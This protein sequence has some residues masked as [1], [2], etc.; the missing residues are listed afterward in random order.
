M[1]RSDLPLWDYPHPAS[2]FSAGPQNTGMYALYPHSSHVSSENFSTVELLFVHI[3]PCPSLPVQSDGKHKEVHDQGADGASNGDRPH[4]GQDDVSEKLP[5]HV[6]FGPD[7]PHR[8]H[9]ADLTVGGADRDPHIGRQKNSQSR[10]NLNAEPTK[11]K[12]QL[13]Y[14]SLKLTHSILFIVNQLLFESEK[15]L[16]GLRQPH[17]CEYFLP[18]IG[19]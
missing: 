8:H 17:H 5:V 6:L 1:N 19:H 13:C 2:F 7:T 10:T 11:N 3:H 12:T 18:E 9:R 14:H 16:W 15:I 4:P